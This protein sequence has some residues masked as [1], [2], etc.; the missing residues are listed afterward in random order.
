[1]RIRRVI[2]KKR[3]KNSR[4]YRKWRGGAFWKKSF[5][6]KIFG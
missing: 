1:M 3:W 4:V 2:I 6:K 5:W